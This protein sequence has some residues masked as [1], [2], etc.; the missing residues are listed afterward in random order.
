MSGLRG[1]R[2]SQCLGVCGVN[3]DSKALHCDV[4]K[5]TSMKYTGSL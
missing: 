2:C 1:S 3:Y 4:C 5:P